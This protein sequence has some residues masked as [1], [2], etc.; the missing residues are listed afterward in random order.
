MNVA[1][2]D[3]Y[4]VVRQIGQGGMATVFL[5][6]DLKHQRSVA[7][8]VLNPEIAATIGRDRF[9]REIE[10]AARLNHPHIL[11]LHDS[12]AAG[13]QLYY[14]MPYIAGESL[15]AL[16]EREKQLPVAEALRLTREIASALG[17]AHGE[18]LIHRDIKPENVL[19]SNGIALVAD[20]G[21][22]RFVDRPEGVRRTT[23]GNVLGTPL[24]MAPE[25]AMGSAD[26]D[27]RADL[28]S[29]GCVLYEM[30][31]GQPPFH[32]ST[33]ATLVYQHVSVVPAPVTDRRPDIPRGISAAL[34]RVLAKLPSDRFATAAGFVEALSVAATGIPTPVPALQEAISTPNNLPRQRTSFVGRVPELAECVR[35]LGEARLLTITGVGGCGK[36]RLASR[37]AE[38]VLENYPAGV[39]WCDLAPVS[40]EGG[41][42]HTVAVVMRVREVPDSPLVETLARH[43]GKDRVLLVLDNC[44]HLVAECGELVDQLL[45]SA[46]NL[47]VLA[48]SREGLGIGGESLFA[49]R[50]LDVPSAA[51]REDFREVAAAGAVRLFVDRARQVAREFTLTEANGT[52]VAEICRRLDGMPLAI[53]LAA[54]RVKMISVE[55]IRSR[56]DDRFRLLTGGDKVLPRHQTLR[57]TIQWSHDL[58]SREEQELFRVLAVFAGGW[59]FD[60][61]VAVA[62]VD[63]DEFEVLDLLTRLADKSLVNVQRETGRESRYTMLETVRQYARDQLEVSG[64][65]DAARDRHLEHFLSILERER[66]GLRVRGASY[67]LTTFLL[68]HENIL[69]AHAWCSHARGGGQRDLRL[70]GCCERYW[71]NLGLI[72]LGLRCVGEALG[73]DGIDLNTL[74]GVRA[75]NTAASLNY[76]RGSYSDAVGHATKALQIARALGDPA[77][78]MESL[79]AL[80]GSA[81]MG[82]NRVMARTCMEELIRE[83]RASDPDALINGLTGL[84]ELMREDSA[85]E[86]AAALLREALVVA[87]DL[88]LPTALT[89]LNLAATLTALGNPAEARVHLR[90]ALQVANIGRLVLTYAVDYTAGLAA[91]SEAWEKSARF[92]GASEV[93]YQRMGAR[94]EPGDARFIEPLMARVREALGEARFDLLY[95][96][97]SGMVLDQAVA[98][99]REWLTPMDPP[100]VSRQ[101]TLPW[102]RGS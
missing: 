6:E 64:D 33:F 29:L 61:A 98:E 52:A 91:A 37:L 99:V 32:G 51:G 10:I 76:I 56:L 9:L 38:A 17:Y 53:E 55:Q 102:R 50:S 101:P 87:A 20:F 18:G 15:R 81:Y 70:V 95:S 24:Y 34:A 92:F 47:R 8:K 46:P 69:S 49:L 5:A 45:D 3:R 67:P 19:L 44:E 90:E 83:G 36:T 58:L 42:A 40:K 22:A 71:L 97:G 41:V 4:R 31:A 80:A 12:G 72:H 35:L 23:V 28:Y 75:L 1:L 84:A 74:E 89:H 96:E 14:V 79:D 21:L 62:G 63:S 27:A 16:L 77:I 60:A 85:H 82:G 54:A 13:D 78:V 7:I 2:P 43:I 100:T 88:R 65:G 94:R 68:E 48:T 66:A 26:V 59:G 57:A 93:A 73:R 25:Q 39:W 86:E 11:P 30:L